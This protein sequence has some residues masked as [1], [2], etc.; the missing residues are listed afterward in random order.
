[1]L[2]IYISRPF[3][4]CLAGILSYL[5]VRSPFPSNQYF[6][7]EI[8]D[9]RMGFPRPSL[10]VVLDSIGSYRNVVID[11]IIL[12]LE[13]YLH[14]CIKFTRLGKFCLTL[15]CLILWSETKFLHRH[16]RAKYIMTPRRY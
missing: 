16:F 15:R 11:S 4:Q 6:G 13:K 14:V 7:L 1:M 9:T 10:N 12:P 5:T 3:F 2:K 8:L